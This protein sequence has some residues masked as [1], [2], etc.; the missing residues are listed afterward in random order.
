MFCTRS[1]VSFSYILFI[2]DFDVHRNMYRALKVFY[3][4]FVCL[5]YKKRRIIANVFILTLKS[6]EVK[7]NDVVKNFF[8]FIQKLNKEINLKINEHFEF[9]CVF[10]MIFINDMSQ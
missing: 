2:D 5:S 7:M 10:A 6:H 3:M 8:K 9:V 4:I 1:H